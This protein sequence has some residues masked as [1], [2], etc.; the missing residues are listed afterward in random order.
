[1]F[2]GGHFSWYVT[3]LP[4]TIRPGTFINL[5]PEGRERIDV[6]QGIAGLRA[7]MIGY[8]GKTGSSVN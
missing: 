7:A 5:R 4:E 8:A 1:L 6:D 2:H 3:K